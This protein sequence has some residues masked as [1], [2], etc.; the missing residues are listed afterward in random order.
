MTLGTGARF[1]RLATD[2]ED[3]I[4]SIQRRLEK[5]QA[6]RELGMSTRNERQPRTDS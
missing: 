1:L 5:R 2:K 4:A 3:Q 6:K